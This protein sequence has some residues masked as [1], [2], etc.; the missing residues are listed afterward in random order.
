MQAELDELHQRME[1]RVEAQA[2]AIRQSERDLRAILD[3]TPTVIGYWTAGLVNRFGNR[4]HRRWLGVDPETLPGRHLRD[5]IGPER[6]AREQPH[7]DAVLRGESRFFEHTDLAP[8]GHTRRHAQ[9]SFHPDIDDDGRVRG[10]YFTLNDVTDIKQAQARAEELAAFAQTLFEHSPVGLGVFDG[11][12][13]C[14]QGNRELARLLGAG[15]HELPGLELPRVSA[16]DLLPLT[17]AA[18]A[19]LADGQARH[20]DVDVQTL[21]GT[22]LQ[23][24]CAW[25]RVERDG[26]GQLLLALQD[27]TA[28]RRAHDALVQARNAA[29]SATRSKSQFLANMSHEIRT[30]MNAIIGLTR[31]ALDDSLPA[32]ARD[33][34]DK[35]HTAAMALMGLLD[36][37]LD[38]SKIEA[39]Q[40]RLEQVPLQLGQVL[41]RVADLFA[42]RLRQKGLALRLDIAPGVP[43]WVR[44]DPLRLGQVLNNLVG[45][46]LKFTD[47][48][49]VTVSVRPADA[50]APVAGLLRFA[51]RDTGIG[52]AP[53]QHEALFEA[54][55]QADNSIT[56]RFGG[57][58]LGLSI[59]RRLVTQMHGSIGVDSAPGQ[60][61]EFWFTARLDP[62]PAPPDE[63]VVA[64]SA[65]PGLRPLQGLRVLLVEDNAI[66]QLV[67]QA[68]LERL[69]AQV[70]RADDGLQALALLHGQPA[71]WFDAVLMDMHMP[72]MDGLETTRRIRAEARTQRL[73]VIGMTAAALPEDRL[74]GLQAGMDDY[75]TKPIVV[76]ALL[77]ALQRWTGRQGRPAAAPTG[78]ADEL[79]G[80]DL[81]P[82]TAQ[83]RGNRMAVQRL[84]RRFASQEA[85]AAAE[86]TALVA[87]GEHPQ[88]AQRLHRLR[89]G[90]ATLGALAVTRAA[91]QAE[92]ALRRGQPVDR[93]LAALDQA[94]QAALA[95]IAARYG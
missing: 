78:A 24:A 69:G 57:T 51:V 42:A 11:Q 46:A 8:D 22:R 80:F 43:A 50:P 2:A 47:H 71:V 48:G 25:A 92:Q 10:F 34:I 64:P 5:V 55:S 77:D 40:L 66:N 6:L 14:L 28:Q 82:L 62:E 16:D 35:A 94:L 3:H 58:G 90:A 39:G 32:Q 7:I 30:P 44:G 86:I 84:L 56:R 53:D 9:S 52:I 61:S 49:Q 93:D 91:L 21:F 76:D 13:R 18:L 72:R 33:F 70:S 88:A 20:L 37:V 73:P 36:D 68:T 89:G 63:P 81:V 15:E 12:L 29:E 67:A 27:S 95:A 17:T 83:L 38:Y 87:R 4:A 59:C 65:G 74:L 45:N 19:T 23:A 85:G 41:Q 60:G 26:Q 75:L 79:P 1:Q 31:L 54:F